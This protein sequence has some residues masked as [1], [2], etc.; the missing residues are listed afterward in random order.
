MGQDKSLW[1]KKIFYTLI[2][3][4]FI[5]KNP[6]FFI[7]IGLHEIGHLICGIILGYKVNKIKLLPFGFSLCFKEVFIKP[8]DNIII[9]LFGPLTNLIFCSLFF[10]IFILFPYEIFYKLIEVNLFLL[11][12]NLIPVGFLDGGRIIKEILS[13]YVS[14]YIA[15]LIINLNGI[16]FGCIMLILSVYT[17]SI[18]SKIV[19]ILIAFSMILNSFLQIKWIKMNIIKEV[20][21]KRFR[22]EYFYK[23]VKVKYY[24]DDT[25]IFSIIKNFCF[26]IE[27]SI[28]IKEDNSYILKDNEIIG[29]YFTKGNITLDECFIEHRRNIK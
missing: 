24:H 5:F 15:N 8:R 20:L 22:K 17:V 3:M 14:F 18:V 26:N 4:F 1:L 9:S 29:F 6:L 11:V 2:I 13:S 10:L 23:R 28:K 16:I 27:Y 21:Y 19:F 7:F 12:F 25:K